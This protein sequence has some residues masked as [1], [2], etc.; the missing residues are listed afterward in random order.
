MAAVGG[1]KINT[2][3]VLEQTPQSTERLIKVHAT[4]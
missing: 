1:E 2:N 3:E 4:G